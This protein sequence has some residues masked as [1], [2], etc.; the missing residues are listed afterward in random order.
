M[1]F[2]MTCDVTVGNFKPFKPNA[3]QW[4]RKIDNYSDSSL[5]KIPG[6]CRLKSAD[7]KTYNNVPTQLKFDEGMKVTISCGYDG[8]NKVRF[9]GFVR[10]I[11][12]NIPIEIECEGY[13]Y[14][15][16]K[17][18]DFSKSYGPTTVKQILKDLTE[19][20]D[21][22]LSD[23]IPDIPIP[24]VVFQNN[25]GVQVLEWLKEKCLLTVYFKFDVLYCGLRELDNY[26]IINY[27]LNWNTIKDDQLKFQDRKEL[28]TVNIR[29]DNR[30]KAGAK[31]KIIA[32]PKNGAEKIFHTYIKDAAFLKKLAED[33]RSK[34]VNRGYEGSL[35]AFLELMA[36]P[37][38]AASITDNKYPERN[39]TYFIEGVDGSFSPT[40]GGRQKIYIGNSLSI[41]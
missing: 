26:K 5:I 20:T 1:S 19:G 14:Q 11:N 38:D 29:F 4:S 15:L 21:I 17:K 6:I 12:F 13:S 16:R 31:E 28:A 25:T 30:T 37:G 10:R 36:E 18:T 8:I 41:G 34:I 7:G 40:G 24:K 39:G 2:R 3:V 23:K 33:V 9:M 22:K 32:G 27:R 35:T